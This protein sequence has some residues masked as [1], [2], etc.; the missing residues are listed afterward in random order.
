MR[1]GGDSSLTSQHYAAVTLRTASR[2]PIPAPATPE[3]QQQCQSQAAPIWNLIGP[4]GIDFSTLSSSFQGAVRQGRVIEACQWALEMHRTD[5]CWDDPP[6]QPIG[7]RRRVGKG[8]V[9]LWTRMFVICAED[10]SLANPAL[11]IHASKLLSIPGAMIYPTVADAERNALQVVIALA[12]SPKSRVVDW[13]TIC[14]VPVPESFD[15][16]VHYNQLVQ[17]L[18]TGN[19]GLAMGYAEAFTTQSLQD[20]QN[21]VKGSVDKGW[22]SQLA[23]GLVV[24]GQ[25]VKHYHN[26]RQIVWAAILRVIQSYRNQQTGQLL[27]PKVNEI[28]MA[29]YIVAHDDRFRWEIPGRL[30]ERMAILA[31]CLRDQV[32]ARGLDL[33]TN[34]F[35]RFEYPQRKFWDMAAVDGY[36]Q[37]HR[38]NP[39]LY[40]VSDVAQDKHNRLGKQLGRDIQHFVEV[41]SFLRHEDPVLIPLNDWYL[42]LCF[43]TRYGA[44]QSPHATFDRSGMT[45]EQYRAWL[46][47]LRERWNLLNKIE[48]DVLTKTITITF[49]EVCE[50]HVGMEKI[51]KLAE[52]GFSVEELQQIAKNFMSAGV[53]VELVDLKAYGPADAEPAALLI[54]RDVAPR[55]LMQFGSTGTNNPDEVTLPLTDKLFE[56]LIGLNWD[57][58]ALM[59]GKVVNKHARHNLCFA[60][61]DQEPNYA[62]GQGRVV[63]F[64]HLPGLKMIR[65]KMVQTFG[66]RTAGSDGKGLLAEGNLY[67]DVDSCYIGA[68]GDSERRIVVG[69]RLGATMSLCYQWYQNSNPIGQ[70]VVLYLNHGDMYIMSFKAVGND[71]KKKLIPTLR[72]SANC[73]GGVAPKKTK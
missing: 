20:K 12:Q 43:Q 38:T 36:R 19:H 60:D 62:A 52:T 42:D 54:L 13:A 5:G 9:N 65:E 73:T 24:N 1:V 16:T 47:K 51:G 22:F 41:K 49:C 72:H 27:Y 57:S 59:K 67:F 7:S 71:W 17:C 58:K 50:N 69:L 61:F 15:V 33:K 6:G 48:N 55:F 11:I 26:K 21:K 70:E 28:A 2:D 45:F 66:A 46:P 29:C 39:L 8:E 30:F 64:D 44:G 32:E 63:A 18:S 25:P 3:W 56:D 68:H 10:I 35:A 4:S 40:G 34:E 14:R 53:R 31:V 37:Y 23:S